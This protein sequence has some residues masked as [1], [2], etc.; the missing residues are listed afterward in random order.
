MSTPENLRR[1]SD[2]LYELQVRSGFD[3]AVCAAVDRLM[4]QIVDWNVTPRTPAADLAL[5]RLMLLDIIRTGDPELLA[6]L[7]QLIV[8]A[9]KP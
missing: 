7:D 1:L 2:R 3:P 8:E 9:Q 4:A 5:T 6:Q